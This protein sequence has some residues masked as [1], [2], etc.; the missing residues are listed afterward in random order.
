[1]SRPV[2]RR[3]LGEPVF[4]SVTTPAVARASM[5]AST[6]A[7]VRV[8]VARASMTA[9]TSAGVRVESSSRMSAAPPATCGQAIEVP[10]MVAEAVSV[11]WPADLMLEPGAKMSRQAPMELKL[12]LPSLLWVEPTVMADGT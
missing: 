3:R 6:W 10:L 4:L 2:Y 7:G 5:T 9:S 8:V 1:V 11:P 12:D